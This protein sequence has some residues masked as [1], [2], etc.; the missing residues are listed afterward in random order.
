MRLIH[1]ERLEL[2]EFVTDIPLYAVLPHR[3]GK[4]EVSFQDV[5]HSRNRDMEG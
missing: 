3:W 2:E 5:L 1:T 4:E